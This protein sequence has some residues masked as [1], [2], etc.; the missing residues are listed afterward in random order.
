[1]YSNVSRTMIICLK[2]KCFLCFFQLRETAFRFAQDE[3]APKAA[4]IDAKNTFDGL[5]VRLKGNLI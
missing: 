1:M 2:K 4:E 3:L 5:R